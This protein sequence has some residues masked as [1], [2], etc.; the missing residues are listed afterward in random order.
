MRLEVENCGKHLEARDFLESFVASLPPVHSLLHSV[1]IGLLP[2]PPY[3]PSPAACLLH[4][5]ALYLPKAVRQKYTLPPLSLSI[6]CHSHNKATK[7]AGITQG[8]LV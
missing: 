6:F 4:H 2:L 3:P 1:D 7:R 5:D 8:F